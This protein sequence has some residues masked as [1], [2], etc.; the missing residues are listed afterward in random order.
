MTQRV[1]T[2][3]LKTQKI[4]PLL[5]DSK[6]WTFFQDDSNNWAL[7]QYDT[8]NCTLLVFL[9]AQRIELFLKYDSKNWTFFHRTQR[10]E[11]FFFFLK[12]S[13]NWT[14]FL[15]MWLKELNFLPW[16]LRIEPFHCTFFIWLK[17]FFYDSKI[18]FEKK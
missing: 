16:L 13:K 5:F 12:N 15:S 2:L 9:R 11:R 18:F 7:F 14:L 6:N 3:C 1:K 8:K 4:K 10:I 17:E